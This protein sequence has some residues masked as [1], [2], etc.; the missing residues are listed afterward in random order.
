MKV[1]S[2]LRR[3]LGGSIVLLFISIL[4]VTGNR[5]INN[6]KNS[7]IDKSL[8]PEQVIEKYFEF[9]NKKD[10]KKVLST[11]TDFNKGIE[12]MEFDKLKYIKIRT[13]ED[14]SYSKSKEYMDYG[15]G[16]V[17]GIKE[18]NVRVYKVN[19]NCK[20]NKD[21]ADYKSGDMDEYFT[22]VRENQ[23]APWLID[24]VGE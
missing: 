18:D 2:N 8:Q 21:T 5:F 6:K 24:E 22:L 16:K 1:N 13:I 19:F 12:F 4:V 9:Y 14:V 3:I 10:S 17:N 23:S 20:Y 15:R 11:M 7:K